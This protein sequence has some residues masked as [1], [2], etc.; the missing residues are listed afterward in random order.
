MQIKLKSKF[1][2]TTLAC[3][4]A[5]ST[6]SA[7]TLTT[8]SGNSPLNS[9]W[10]TAAN[11][12]TPLNTSDT[13]SLVFS[14]NLR[15]TATNDLSGE[16]IVDSILFANT[17]ATPLPSP[18]SNF[19]LK[20]SAATILLQSTTPA[21]SFLNGATVTTNAATSGTLSDSIT[22]A[23]AFGGTATFNMG[24]NHNLLL[25]GT[26]SGGTLV[27]QGAGDLSFTGPNNL[28]ALKIDQGLVHVSNLALNGITGLTV[29]IGSSGQ[30]GTLRFAG[31]GSG[32]TPVPTNMKFNLNGDANI[33][34]TNVGIITFN[35]ANFNQAVAGVT[36]PVTLSLIGGGAIA[37]G[38]QTINGVIQDNSASGKVGV[39]I[40][41][42]TSQNDWVLN[43]INTYTG[44]T[45]IEANGKLLMN[46]SVAAGSTTTSYGYLGGSGTFGGAVI[47]SSGTLAPGGSS[48][49][50]VIVD[51]VGDLTMASLSLSGSSQTLMQINGTTR[52]TDY[53]GLDISD[54]GGLINGGV[55]SLSFGNS[56]AFA[57]NTTFDL[58]NFSGSQSGNFSDVTSTGYY[59]GTWALANGKWTLESRG[60]ILSFTPSTG[61][62]VAEPAYTNQQQWRFTNFS[63]YD[64]LGSAADS[65][66][67]DGDGLSN[68]M[69]YALGTGPNSSGVMPAVLALNGANLEY[70]YTRSTAAKDNGVTY[71]I[72]WSETL[73]AGSWSTQTVTEQIQGTQGALETVKA[74]ISKG[75]T[76]NRFLRLKV[77]AVSGN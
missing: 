55:L 76:G 52:G 6:A 58:F 60:Q 20:K 72:E 77:Q 34:T 16:V 44:S 64:S 63:S 9:N 22:S 8:W 54:G 31:V 26:L 24:L 1:L 29:D 59:A 42:A 18:T 71:Q 2:A 68:L 46:G 13:F 36:T 74:S 15:T 43:G 61:D 14:G 28:V 32:T 65:A 75:T 19:T 3:T 45:T 10:S 56:S 5:A 39:T 47:V 48:T 62:L 53:D 41:N 49:G 73:E 57:N 38:T 11:W 67:P 27:K 37:K 51:T 25:S 7:G 66:D 30:T 12:S 40:G 23:I 70:T 21:L 17:A 50:G 4:A 33:T 69:E 35:A